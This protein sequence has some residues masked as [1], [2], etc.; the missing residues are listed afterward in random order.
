[1][2]ECPWCNQLVHL[3]DNVCP[4]CKQEVLPEHFVDE[5]HA[6]EKNYSMDVEENVEELSIEDAIIHK[7]KCAKCGTCECSVKEVAV[8][9]TGFSKIFDI[10]NNHFLFV[11]CLNCGFVEAYN[12]DVLRGHK[13]GKL[14]TIMDI[15]FGV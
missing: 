1:M 3:K 9:G 10:E 12:P 14:G 11:S 8:N 13:S 5:A 7:F 15:L 6:V 2:I 4:N